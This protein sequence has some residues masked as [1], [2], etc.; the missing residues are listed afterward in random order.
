MKH[1]EE[2]RLERLCRLGIIVAAIVILTCGVLLASQWYLGSV[3][4]TETLT[5]NKGKEVLADEMNYYPTGIQLNEKMPELTFYDDKGTA[6]NLSEY[7]GKNV[8]LLFWASWCKYCKQEFESMGAFSKLL[9]QYEDMEFILVD[10]LDGKKETKD[11]ALDYLKEKSVPFPTFFD[12]ELKAYQSLGIK[13][14]PTLLGVDSQGILRCCIPGITKAAD[15]LEALLHYVRLGGAYATE[16]FVTNKLMGEDGG[17]HTNYQEIDKASPSG[18]DV[19]SESQGILM[20]YA[21]V[22]KDRELFQRSL[23]YVRKYMQFSNYLTGWRVSKEK[24]K[25][26]S[27]ALVDDLRIYKALVNADRLWGGY[28]EVLKPWGE[29]ILKYNTIPNGFIDC[30]DIKEDR[31]SDRITLSF[32]DLEAISLLVKAISNETDFYEQSL[33]LIAEGYIS[34]EFPFYYSWY[35]YKKKKYSSADLNMA[36]AVLTLLHLAEVGE[37]K[38]ETV[39]WL[40]AAL[41][42]GGIKAR[43]TV[44]GEVVKDFNYESTA[45]YAIAARIGE[46]IGNQ[47]IVTRAIA[48]MEA[49]RINDTGTTF[50]GAF[51]AKEGEDIYSFDQCMAL[52]TYGYLQSQTDSYRD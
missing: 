42:K 49:L 40:E 38:Q 26:S 32:L 14:V 36:E 52:L 23:A 43:Y 22:K 2:N 18:Y 6:V 27:N 7:K 46:I 8:I 31:R 35:D 5:N 30:Y 24:K 21:V 48:R 47:N 51:T 9:D 15:Q 44:A 3:A 50:N 10:K 34:K 20:E 16:D 41:Q 39:D 28:E 19:L 45:I 25:A 13:I 33:K 37:I 29:S 17:V 4:Q 1:S 11:Q 12:E